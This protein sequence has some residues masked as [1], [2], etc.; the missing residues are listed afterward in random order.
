MNKFYI[1]IISLISASNVIAQEKK[2]DFDKFKANAVKN[3]CECFHKIEQNQL[4]NR[5]E[6]YDKIKSCIDEEVL[7]FQMIDKLSAIPIETNEKKK[8]DKKEIKINIDTN[9]KSGEYLKYYRA[10]ES[11]LFDNCDNFRDIIASSEIGLENEIP[12]ENRKALDYYSEGLKAVKE[13][14][15]KSAAEFFANAVKEDPK[16]YY[17]WDNL[18]VNLRR[19]ERYD[20]AIEAYQKSL[21]INP[22][23]AMPLQ[24]IAVAYIHQKNYTAAIE[25]YEKFADI[26]PNNP[27]TF[28]CLGH[29]YIVDLKE[30]EKGLD[31]MCKA[32]NKYIENNSPYRS[33]AETVISVAYQAMKKN[34]QEEKFMEILKK[35][36]IHIGE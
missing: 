35:N 20:E 2:S 27:E 33:D 26:Y 13:S 34:N 29:L 5:K 19:L 36:N 24:N 11:D 12:S 32:Y 1:L 15:W 23:G 31:Y 28:Y 8:K 21:Q 30:Y 7:A 16:F 22:Y 17:A 6:L 3:S 14:N 25:A 9:E 10:I 4:Y 18:G